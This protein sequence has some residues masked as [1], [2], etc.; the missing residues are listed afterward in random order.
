MDRIPLS[1]NELPDQQGGQPGT[2][3]GLEQKSEQ[4]LGAQRKKRDL[5]EIVSRLQRNS[6]LQTQNAAPTPVQQDKNQL[7]LWPQAIRG[8]PNALL[9]NSLFTVNKVRETFPRR[10][11]LAS[12]SDIEIRFMGVRFN[13]TDL[14]VWEMILH[15][16]RLQP[17]GC[18]V[19]FSAHSFLKALGRGTGATQHEQLKEEVARLRGGTVEMTWKN[20]KKT[21]VGG[22][23]EKAY[24]DEATQQYIV[25]L[26]EKLLLLYDS[27]Y[28]HINWEQRQALR[29]NLA[30]WL[31][32]FYSSHA[33]P[34]SYK[35]ETLRELCGSGTKALWK[36]RQMLKFALEDLVTV[37]FIKDWEI[38]RDGKLEITV[39]PSQSQVKHLKN[40]RAMHTR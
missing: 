19:L 29:S 38:T 39:Y 20:D 13:Q 34:Y 21:F 5:Q 36:F 2:L 22:L 3:D 28:S 26:D 18:K 25:T 10:E 27:G 32:G 14:D 31:H 7:P 9:R 6:Q 33:S 30:K 4:N 16:A 11:L 12:N 23:L 35:I 1:S 8:V 24:R 15:L 17:V 40:K 37:G